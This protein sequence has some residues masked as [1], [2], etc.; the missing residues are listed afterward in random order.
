MAEYVGRGQVVGDA[1]TDEMQ[2]PLRSGACLAGLPFWDSHSSWMAV[3]RCLVTEPVS[4]VEFGGDRFSDHEGHCTGEPQQCGHL[5]AAVGPGEGELA[6]L[7][8][9]VAGMTHGGA[10]HHPHG[11]PPASSP[12]SGVGAPGAAGRRA[13]SSGCPVC[14]SRFSSAPGGPGIGGAIATGRCVC[15][16]QCGGWLLRRGGV[17][18][19]ARAMNR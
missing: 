7:L 11:N 14:R 15:V 13:R 2:G 4:T 10:T 5:H 18:P 8:D 9:Y 6:Q 17:P 3:R 19:T 12:L 16:A 1:V